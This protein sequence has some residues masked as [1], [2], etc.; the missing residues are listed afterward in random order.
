MEKAYKLLALQE[1]ISNKKAKELIDRG[2][3][4]VAGKKLLIARGELPETTRFKV[5]EIER[6]EVLFED[7]NL[8]AINKPP[9]LISEDITFE[10]ARALHRLDK[11]TSG[12]MLFAKSEA[13][14]KIA[15]EEFRHKR[16][17][18]E[19][20]AWVDGILAE[21]L[22]IDA[23]I[24]TAKDKKAKSKISYKKGKEA[25]T[26]IEP[27]LVSGKKSKIKAVIATGRTH[28]IR[29]HLA[30]IEHP[31]I[32]DVTYGKGSYDRMLLHSFRLRIFDYEFEA[33]EPKGF[34]RFLQ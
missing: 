3:V 23:P 34:D 13:F 18:K 10:N 28:Q 17:Y 31:I 8:I 33:P 6:V 21:P 4:F 16:V 11:E 19:Y 2:L 27:I 7:E 26:K 5:K 12:V 20:V 9:F 14:A 15:I 29:V 25:M 30:S 1:G 24:E 32:G 22:E